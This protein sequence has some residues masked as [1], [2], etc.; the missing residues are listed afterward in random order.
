MTWFHLFVIKA[1][2]L[3]FKFTSSLILSL[4]VA[5]DHLECHLFK[6]SLTN[7]QYKFP[8]HFPFRRRG[9]LFT[10]TV[11]KRGVFSFP[12]LFY[13]NSWI[14][15]YVSC[16]VLCVLRNEF[17]NSKLENNSRVFKSKEFYEGLVCLPIHRLL[18][19]FCFLFPA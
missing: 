8:G 12:F 10:S 6:R 14:I 11:H 16:C 9:G 1:D 17:N 13:G 18:I 15:G 5:S 3:N 2:R 4:G 19:Y 7:V